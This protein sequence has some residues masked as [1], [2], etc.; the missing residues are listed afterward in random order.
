MNIVSTFKFLAPASFK[1]IPSFAE[2]KCESTALHYA[3]LV[4]DMKVVDLLLRNGAKWV[5]KD[6]NK[7]LPQEY[8][9]VHGEDSVAEFKRLCEAEGKRRKDKIDEEKRIKDLIAEEKRKKD[10]IA[11]EKRRKDQIA[12]E[13]RN[14]DQ[15][16]EERRRKDQIAEEKR[17][18]EKV[19]EERRRKDKLDEEKRRKEIEDEEARV[20]MAIERA[21]RAL[22]VEELR[23]AG[24]LAEYMA[25][26]RQEVYAD[27]V[28][29][30]ETTKKRAERVSKAQK[31]QNK[32]SRK[33]ECKAFSISAQ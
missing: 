7:M 30:P 24:E 4:G 27:V 3:C 28:S 6:G 25:M 22:E 12:E 13:K 8:A 21:Q 11:E 23:L 20:K 31:R 1:I 26:E 33:K 15:I 14:K 29:D 18:K 19:D 16:D 5:E 17:R 10:Q 2:S 32:A 9:S